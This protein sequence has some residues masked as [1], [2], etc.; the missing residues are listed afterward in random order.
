MSL[1]TVIV[2]SLIVLLAAPLLAQNVDRTPGI[3]RGDTAAYAYPGGGEDCAITAGDHVLAIARTDDGDLLIYAGS[4]ECA[5]AVWL[6]RG[7]VADIEWAD[8]SALDNLPEIEAP[9]MPELRQ[10]L[11]DCPATTPSAPTPK[12]AGTECLR[13]PY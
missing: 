13:S 10:P 8:E 2:P 4:D 5:G 11:S 1:R 6:Q 9:D 7:D 3:A 12:P